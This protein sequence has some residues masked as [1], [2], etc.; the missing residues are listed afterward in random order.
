MK[1]GIP[2]SII[3]IKLK[4]AARKGKLAIDDRIEGVKF[5]KNYF[6]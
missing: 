5:Y 6:L 1:K 4:K 2:L 3:E